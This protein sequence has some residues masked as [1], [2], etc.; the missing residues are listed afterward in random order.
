[1]PKNIFTREI[2]LM[3]VLNLK[4]VIINLKNKKMKRI[5]MGLMALAAICSVGGAFAFTPKSSK[6]TTSY[7]AVKNGSGWD[8]HAGTPP[9]NLACQPAPSGICT[10]VTNTTPTNSSLNGRSD[11]HQLYQLIN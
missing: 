7:Y 11:Q 10:I 8:F 3:P 2:R 6:G 9:A 5:K 1:M 4:P